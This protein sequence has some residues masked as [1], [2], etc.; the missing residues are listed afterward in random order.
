MPGSV[1]F[2]DLYERGQVELELCPQG[3]LTERIRAGGAGIGGFYTPDR[4]GHAPRR[5]A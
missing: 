1:V 2:D 4:R 3:T 5:G